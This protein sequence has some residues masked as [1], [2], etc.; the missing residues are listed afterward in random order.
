MGKGFNIISNKAI[1]LSLH[2]PAYHKKIL[3]IEVEGHLS[4]DSGVTNENR[5]SWV[6]QNSPSKFL[7]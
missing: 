3:G 4:I 7:R 2:I 1:V 5:N 6:G